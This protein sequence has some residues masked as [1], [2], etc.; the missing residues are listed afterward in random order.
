MS[1]DISLAPFPVTYRELILPGRINANTTIPSSVFGG[2]VITLSGAKKGTTTDG[3][4][5]DGSAN[6]YINC[7]AIHNAGAK[8]ACKFRIKLEQG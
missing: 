6:S 7:G 4:H 8:F 1:K 3:V 5:G 2:H